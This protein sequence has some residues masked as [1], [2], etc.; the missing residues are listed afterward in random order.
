MA[1]RNLKL[2]KSALEVLSENP[3][4]TAQ[5]IVAIAA[6]SSNSNERLFKRFKKSPL[7]IISNARPGGARD[8]TGGT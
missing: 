7:L 3:D 2:A 5:A 6:M 8:P 4:D 1:S